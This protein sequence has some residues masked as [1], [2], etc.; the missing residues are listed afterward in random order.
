M[1]SPEIILYT[2]NNNSEV[3]QKWDQYSQYIFRGSDLMN[4]S[5]QSNPVDS[6]RDGLGFRDHIP[7]RIQSML[8][9]YEFGDG[10]FRQ[11]SLNFIRQGK[12]MEDYEDNASWYG[13]LMTCFPV[14]HDL[15]VRQLRGY[16]TWRT[17]IR[18]GSFTRTCTAFVYLY[19]YE[20]LN[21]IG[22]DSAAD[23][24]Q[25]LLE[26]RDG[27]IETGMGDITMKGN[28]RRWLF[29]FAVTHLFHEETAMRFVEKGILERDHAIAVLRDPGK[30]DD[31]EV[32]QAI[33][34]FASSKTAFSSVLA[35]DRSRGVRLF[36]EIWR[37]IASRNAQPIDSPLPEDTTIFTLCFG[38]EE[39]R[40]WHPLA[41]AV[42]IDVN[43]A[44][45]ISFQLDEC[46]TY[47]RHE[48]KWQVESYNSLS[49]SRIAFMS[50]L[51]SADRRLRSMVKSGHYLHHKDGDDWAMPYIDKALE[52]IRAEEAEAARPKI[53]IDLSGLDRIREDAGITRDSLLTEE[54]M[55]LSETQYGPEDYN[56]GD[57]KDAC[58]Y[59]LTET[60]TMPAGSEHEDDSYEQPLPCGLSEIQTAVLRELL[61]GRSADDLISENHLM[62]SVVA[63]SI[64]EILFDEIGDNVIECTDDGLAIVEDYIDEV[65]ALA[66]GI[67]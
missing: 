49:G 57:E 28:L 45:D 51:H 32:F 20:L 9:L 47:F 7:D 59:E 62:T 6:A 34:R 31:E 17:Q 65:D 33:R 23:S 39:S 60:N 67:G 56:G 61:A 1:Q 37:H 13:N 18:K 55:D 53:T 26:F 41:N 36:A 64:N 19:I 54:E 63:D 25:K 12:Y 24:L 4:R 50:L 8:A 3:Q 2:G 15:N 66:G 44:E 43:G 38:N 14:Y 52:E 29:E 40:P 21:G 35:K 27:Y 30:Y 48:G 22:T 16:F 5:P 11:K 58:D 46:R 42:Y 10:S